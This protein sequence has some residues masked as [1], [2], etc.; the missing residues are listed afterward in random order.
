MSAK[1]TKKKTTPKKKEAF[2]VNAKYV[3]KR[4][5]ISE[6][7]TFLAEEGFYIFKVLKEAN[8][9]EIRK[10]I[11]KR[12]GVDVESVRTVN[13]PSKKRRTGRIEGVKKGYKKAIV[14]VKEGQSID[15]MD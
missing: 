2:D 6:K 10:E 9:I 14:K 5:H 7:A 13:I 8:K 1:T 4:P 12:Y 3:L 15:L 11:E